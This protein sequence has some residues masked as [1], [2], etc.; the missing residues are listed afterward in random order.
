MK[1]ENALFVLPFCLIFALS[2]SCAAGA[3]GDVEEGTFSYGEG[4]STGYD[5]PA[6]QTAAST[7]VYLSFYE[8]SDY[9]GFQHIEVTQIPD[10]EM[11]YTSGLKTNQ[12]PVVIKDGADVVG[13]GNLG[14]F[15][16]DEYTTIFLYVSSWDIGDRTGT[17]E[18]IL[19]Y[20]IGDFGASP[21]RWSDTGDLSA[22]YPVGFRRATYNKLL[23]Y[24]TTV[25][26]AA[27]F[28][29]DYVC[30]EIADGIYELNV[31]KVVNGKNSMS[32]WNISSD[33]G[34]LYN[35]T[36]NVN[37]SFIFFDAPLY[38]LCSDTYG[39]EYTDT[40][41][42]LPPGTVKLYGYVFDAEGKFLLNSSKITFGSAEYTTGEDGYYYFTKDAGTYTLKAEKSG[43]QDLN[44]GVGVEINLSS[45]TRYD[46]PLIKN[47]S[48]YSGTCTVAGVVLDSATYQP[49][50]NA[51]VVIVNASYDRYMYTNDMGYFVFYN[52]T[53][54]TYSLSASA[55]GYYTMQ[56]EIS[57]AD[58]DTAYYYQLNLVSV[59]A[60]EPT[61]T[62]APGEEESPTID[63]WKT[64]FEMMGL[65]DYMG[66]ILAFLCMLTMGAGFGYIV[67][68]SAVGV[69]IGAFFGY[70]IDVA[71]GWL[72][73]WTVAVVVC[74]VAFFIAKNVA[75]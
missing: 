68:G 73:V 15:R 60:A 51:R 4:S 70:V 48:V 10:D 16:G 32:T 41:F 67:H 19:D 59:S 55:D 69:L 18:L 1:S 56:K 57:L 11:S 44:G 71:I 35:G 39:N 20:D 5:V 43:Y 6:V 24:H 38:V 21:M 31:T 9:T 52:L 34:V 12:V 62:P 75:K 54:S 61:P 72:P 37:E 63:G 7:I 28:R 65:L 49:V 2:I 30:T 17:K 64:I 29:N 22:T 46:I 50:A 36:S 8:I 3:V 47:A 14:F 66:Y 42:V 53:N 13:T 74:V 58:L 25:T 45:T 40:L 33:C 27:Y 26:Y 23:S